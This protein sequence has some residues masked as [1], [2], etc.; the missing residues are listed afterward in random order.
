MT[1]TLNLDWAKRAEA[2]QFCE[3]CAG[4]DDLLALT[5]LPERTVYLCRDCLSDAMLRALDRM[6]VDE[7][8]RQVTP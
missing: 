3:H 6:G 8:I 5:L 4:R 7:F 2:G 1:G